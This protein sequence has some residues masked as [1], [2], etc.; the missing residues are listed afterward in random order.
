MANLND[1]MA[2]SLRYEADKPCGL[3][4]L[5]LRFMA[6]GNGFMEWVIIWA[7]FCWIERCLSPLLLLHTFLSP[8]FHVH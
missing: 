3:Y 7:V 2:K 6:L 4:L 1:F 8:H 5:L